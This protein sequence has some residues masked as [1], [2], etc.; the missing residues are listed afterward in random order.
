MHVKSHPAASWSLSKDSAKGFYGSTNGAMYETHVPFEQTLA[1]KY[2][3]DQSFLHSFGHENEVVVGGKK[4]SVIAPK[5]GVTAK[6]KGTEYSYGDREKLFD[7]WKKDH[8]GQLPDAKHFG[9]DIAAHQKKVGT[10]VQLSEMGGAAMPEE[11]VDYKK[12]T[13]LEYMAHL[14]AKVKAFQAPLIAAGV[15]PAP[16]DGTVS[17]LGSFAEARAEMDA[18]KANGKH[19][20]SR[21]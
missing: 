13:G 16:P 4:D 17:P 11:E 8:G 12:M 5:S 20:G 18:E 14:N 19:Q 7:E 9:I 15:T 6:Y 2:A 10:K 1:D 3:D 21:K